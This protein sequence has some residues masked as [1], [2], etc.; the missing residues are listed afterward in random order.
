VWWRS[1]V[2][3]VQGDS[4]LGVLTIGIGDRQNAL[5]RERIGRAREM[6]DFAVFG[7]RLSG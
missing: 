1:T 3:Q 2:T 4:T 7:N 5:T 6:Q